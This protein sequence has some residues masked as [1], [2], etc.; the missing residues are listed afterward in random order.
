MK[1]VYIPGGPNRCLNYRN[2]VVRCGGAV[3]ED[4]AE[5]EMLLLTGGGDVEPKLYG[6]ENTASLGIKPERDQGEL[7][8]LDRFWREGK[9]I[10]GICRGMQ[11][12]NVWLGG[13][14][15]QD[16]SGHSQ[17]GDR[18]SFHGSCIASSFMYDIFG[19]SVTVNSAHHQAVDRLGDGLRAIQWAQDGTVEA[20]VHESGL[21]AAVQ[22][23]PERV[24]ETGDRLI[25]AILG[26]EK[27]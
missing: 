21:I 25:R 1:R 26:R 11:L 13:T 22:W 27:K 7:A 20:V 19:E 24:G 14:L 2:A 5:A 8:L 10:F 4:P 3:T 23:H 16:I 9:E 6:A 12:I 17:I 18:D 15:L